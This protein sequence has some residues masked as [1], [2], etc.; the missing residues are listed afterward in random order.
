MQK[1]SNKFYLK[2]FILQCDC[3]IIASIVEKTA[4]AGTT[5]RI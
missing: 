1:K 4:F 2:L 5:E 3:G